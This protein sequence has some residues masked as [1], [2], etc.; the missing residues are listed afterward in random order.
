LNIRNGI[1]FFTAFKGILLH[2]KVC[3]GATG[4][5]DPTRNN[6]LFG[7]SLTEKGLSAY[8]DNNLG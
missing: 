1:I 5:K 3:M 6:Q 2:K 4:P 7:P 8:S